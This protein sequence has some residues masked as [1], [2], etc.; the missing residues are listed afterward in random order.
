THD[1]ATT[2]GW[3]ESDATPDE[4]MR[5]FRYLGRDIPAEQLP[6]ELI[7]LAMMS[8]A[9]TVIFPMQDILGLDG[10]SRMNR[11]GS[12]RG[13][14]RWQMEKD[15]IDVSM[16]LNLAIITQIF[17]RKQDGNVRDSENHNPA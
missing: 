13:N 5:L 7:R 17:G 10:T 1:N 3:L 11:P 6:E 12:D 8:V 2:R 15:V 16:T 14:W 4:K 9:D